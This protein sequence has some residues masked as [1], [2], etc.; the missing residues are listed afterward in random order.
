MSFLA[1][2]LFG[3]GTTESETTTNGTVSSIS[4]A[5]TVRFFFIL[6]CLF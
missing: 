4:G 1:T 2:K 6:F 5:E 3:L